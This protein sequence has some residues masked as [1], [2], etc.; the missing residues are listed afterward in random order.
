MLF[1]LT[2]T[3]IWYFEIFPLGDYFIILKEKIKKNRYN[4]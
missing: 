4:Q 3:V 2:C 1:Y